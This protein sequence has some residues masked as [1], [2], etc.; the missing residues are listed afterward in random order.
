MPLTAP[1]STRRAASVLLTVLIVAVSALVGAPAHADAIRGK[2]WHLGFLRAQDAWR[3]S[4]GLGVTVAVLDSG[5]DANHPDLRGQVLPGA[6]FVD[7]TTDG[8]KDVVGHGTTVASLIAG[9]GDSDGVIGLAYR[10][11]ILPVRVLDPQNKYDSAD[12]VAR[13]LRWAVD[14]GAR[15]VNLSLGSADVAPVLSDALQYAFDHD[16]VVVACDGNLSNNRG[17]TVWH[18]AREPGVIAVSGVTRTGG[19]WSGSLQGPATVLAAPAADM[20][21]ANPGGDYWAVQGTSFAAPLVSAT[22][23]L[24]RAK[25]PTMS[26]ADVVNRLIRTAWDFGPKGRDGQFGF[27]IVNPSG[28]LTAKLPPVSANPLLPSAPPATGG[29]ADPTTSPGAPTGVEQPQADPADRDEPILPRSVFALLALGCVGL[30]MIAVTGVAIVLLISIRR[31]QRAAGSPP[32]AYLPPGPFPGHDPAPPSPA[33]PGAVPPGR[34]PTGRR[35]TWRR[36]TWHRPTW[37]RPTWRRPTWR[38]PT[39]AP[40]HLGAVPPGAVLPGTV[41]P[42]AVAPGTPAGGPHVPAPP[43]TLAP[44]GPP[45]SL[46]PPGPAPAAPGPAPHAPAPPPHAPQAAHAPQPPVPPS[47]TRPAPAPPAPAPPPATGPPSQAPGGEPGQAEA[48]RRLGP[49][50]PVWRRRPPPQP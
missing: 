23:A 16:V 44:P 4:T 20:T 25:Y 15:V 14:R 3:Q 36:P 22:A 39:W 8:R 17:T 46:S 32:P 48:P 30:I 7:K 43:R 11:K 6:D 24:I 33:P 12:V 27:G 21:G 50:P 5:V 37:R 29:Q 31:G 45:P 41:P 47:P 49:W 26:S 28:A 38:R 1:R 10:A 19:F 42:G 18:P 40:S 9:R 13:A 35:P 2:Q 34:R